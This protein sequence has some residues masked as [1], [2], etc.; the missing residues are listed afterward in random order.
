MTTAQDSMAPLTLD[1]LRREGTTV[2]VERSGQYLGVS[3]AFAYQ[4]AREGQLPTIK[5]GTRRV[6]VPTSALLR[7]LEGGDVDALLRRV[8]PATR[9]HRYRGRGHTAAKEAADDESP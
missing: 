2:S 6:R 9:P 5:L 7:L 8:E 1:D 4:M 3:R